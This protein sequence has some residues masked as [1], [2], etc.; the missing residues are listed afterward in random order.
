[1]GETERLRRIEVA[2][3]KLLADIDRGFEH[4]EEE[5]PVTGEH[6]S[7]DPKV[8]IIGRESWP[9]LSAELRDALGSE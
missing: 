1:M 3:Q 2:A 5:H 6:M 4:W 8:V 9:D 7:G